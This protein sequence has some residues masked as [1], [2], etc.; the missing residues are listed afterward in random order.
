MSIRR[1]FPI[2]HHIRP[3]NRIQRMIHRLRQDL[4]LIRPH[5]RLLRRNWRMI[6]SLIKTCIYLAIIGHALTYMPYIIH[7]IAPKW[8]YE[9]VDWFWS[10]HFHY[11]RARYYYFKETSG[12]LLTLLYNI[13]IVKICA[14]FSDILFLVFFVFLGYEVIDFFLFWW[15][16]NTQFDLY[17]NLFWTMMVLINAAS[18]PYDPERIGRIKSLF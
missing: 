16:W 4:T 13:I 8:S 12:N 9:S 11:S 5:L 2:R 7:S 10:K 14:K 3:R 15:D 18:Y 1:I 17:V 6:P